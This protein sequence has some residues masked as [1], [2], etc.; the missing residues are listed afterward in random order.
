M[1][2]PVL[3]RRFPRGQADRYSLQSSSNDDSTIDDSKNT[4][5]LFPRGATAP[6]TISHHEGLPQLD[7]LL[8]SDLEPS[9]EIGRT[10]KSPYE[11]LERGTN[12]V[13]LIKVLPSTEPGAISC[14]STTRSLAQA[15]IYTAL[16]YTWGRPSPD[17]SIT[18][19]DVTILVRKNLWRCLHNVRQSATDRNKL[20]WIDALC[21]DQHNLGERTHQVGLM[22]SI[23]STAEQ[24][25]VWLGPAYGDSNLALQTLSRWASAENVPDAEICK[26]WWKPHGAALRRL[27]E[28]TYWSR[29]WIL[30]ELVLAKDVLLICGSRRAPGSAL[31]EFL[32]RAR[33]LPPMAHR[34]ENLEY[35]PTMKSRAMS[36][37]QEVQ[38]AR[39]ETCLLDQMRISQH[40]RCHEPRDKVYALL[41]IV[42]RGHD[43]ILPDY[44]VGLPSLLNAV[45]RNHHKHR[46][47]NG[48]LDVRRQ[49]QE[50]CETVGVPI[51]AMFP[52]ENQDDKKAPP[53][54]DVKRARLMD[55]ES[56]LTLWWA[57]LYG[58]DGVAE[59]LVSKLDQGLLNDHLVH[60][61]R[62]GNLR[63]IQ[64]W[65]STGLNVVD[66]KDDRGRNL[67]GVATSRDHAAVTNAL[68][69]ESDIDVNSQDSEGKAAIHVAAS[70]GLTEVLKVLL[71][72]T[73]TNVN[74]FNQD[75]CTPL[76]LAIR[77]SRKYSIQLLMERQDLD[78]NLAST[79]FQTPF[80]RRLSADMRKIT[81]LEFARSNNQA[82]VVEMLLERSDTE[83]TPAKWVFQC[84][85]PLHESIRMRKDHILRLLLVRPGVNV[86]YLST[87]GDRPLNVALIW[88]TASA[89]TMLMNHREIDLT[90]A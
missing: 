6:S 50:L 25:M 78:M 32:L 36:I 7:F 23:Y 38:R 14:R 16:S 35:D 34:D 89:I 1:S 76:H 29:L 73:E 18:L 17:C 51:A 48:L 64:F 62:E 49:C 53:P 40:L 15:P 46:S 44:A 39:G 10:V 70:F 4:A 52:L 80:E 31:S 37:F 74:M 22:S 2:D 41:G 63:V 72:H 33:T 13:R 55:F 79:R 9:K 12:V 5:E 61:A 66:C 82:D 11:E 24:V 90:L 43:G 58:H 54:E 21:I 20:F 83:V 45:L 87:R 86:N 77:Q 56:G 8:F 75:M 68:L 47:A 19:N 84:H 59:M 65:L 67:V 30:Q 26:I 42:G 85:S 28:R 69:N 27:C 71:A 60:C 3:V 88:G 57:R 81:P